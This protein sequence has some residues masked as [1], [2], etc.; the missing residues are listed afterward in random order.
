MQGKEASC[1][2]ISSLKSGSAGLVS[3]IAERLREEEWLRLRT[4]SSLQFQ[5]ALLKTTKQ[6]QKGVISMFRICLTHSSFM[7]LTSPSNTIQHPL[8]IGEE[9][10]RFW[11]HSS[12]GWL[13]RR[14]Q[15]QC[16]DAWTAER[17]EWASIH[18]L[19]SKWAQSLKV[20]SMEMKLKRHPHSSSNP[21]H[22][23]TSS[24]AQVAGLSLSTGL[25]RTQFF[26]TLLTI[27]RAKKLAHRVELFTRQFKVLTQWLKSIAI[28]SDNVKLSRVGLLCG[29]IASHFSRTTLLSQMKHHSMRRISE[30]MEESFSS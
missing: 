7:I 17:T 11:I 9:L 23:G 4:T 3:R 18:S 10:S 13:K 27:S 2:W 19:I 12:L 1:T 20:T 14:E 15:S 25:A 16:W 28:L 21:T 26:T 8:S 5:I 30:V 29:T 24:Q 22:S 6:V